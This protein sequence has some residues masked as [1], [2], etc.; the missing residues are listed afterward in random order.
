MSRCVQGRLFAW[1]V[2][3]GVAVLGGCALD[4][5]RPAPPETPG[6][7]Q[8]A[9]TARPLEAYGAEPFY[10]E[11]RF[12]GTLTI[13]PLPEEG[14]SLLTYTGADQPFDDSWAAKKVEFVA[15]RCHRNP[16]VYPSNGV[17][18]GN[19]F[20]GLTSCRYS[21]VT[22][23]MD[24]RNLK[25]DFVYNGGDVERPR[26]V[27]N[28]YGYFFVD[29]RAAF[30]R[31]F[32]AEEPATRFVL[33]DGKTYVCK[34][35]WDTM[36][37]KNIAVQAEGKAAIK[38]SLEDA[39]LVGERMEDA[40]TITPDRASYPVTFGSNRFFSFADN[41]R[42]D[43]RFE[44]IDLLP[45]HY[46]PPDAGLNAGGCGPFFAHQ[47][48]ADYGTNLQG[49]WI[50]GKRELVNC[51]NQA[52]A[53]KYARVPFPG[54]PWFFGGPLCISNNGGKLTEDS[55]DIAFYQEFNFVD[56]EWFGCEPMG[57]RSVNRAGNIF[58]HLNGTRK[59]LHA[60]NAMTNTDRFPT[61]VRFK[62]DVV[63]GQ[64]RGL[65]A[66]ELMDGRVT[67]YQLAS[68]TYWS[69]WGHL[70]HGDGDARRRG[71]IGF[72]D[73]LRDCEW[74][75][76]FPAPGHFVRD[77]AP[78]TIMT[79]RTFSQLCLPFVDATTLRT[80]E[81]IPVSASR[82]ARDWS[83]AQTVIRVDGELNRKLS[84]TQFVFE[85]YAFQALTSQ[86]FLVGNGEKRGE[87]G[88][89]AFSETYPDCDELEYE[90]PADGNALKTV[91]IVKRSRH[92]RSP[93]NA[94]FVAV[95]YWVYELDRPVAQAAPVFRV[96]KS[97]LE[98]ALNPAGVDADIRIYRAGTSPQG[99][100]WQYLCYSSKS[101]NWEMRNS[102]IRGYMRVSDHDQAVRTAADPLWTMSIVK[103]WKACTVDGSSAELWGQNTLKARRDKTGDDRFTAIVD[104]TDIGAGPGNMP[105]PTGEMRI[106]ND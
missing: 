41:T 5:S 71:W 65:R 49:R 54:E 69:Q 37:G 100:G 102:D 40:N 105:S 12:Y 50:C 55:S 60:G 46:T 24:G 67:A 57:L 52:E 93:T 94:P 30:A 22:E 38:F 26:A 7:G 27:T 14:K 45:P 34:G 78:A 59:K 75:L 2:A 81:M 72:R 43:V 56:V 103:S 21:R 6:A 53:R 61:R 90:D 80:F 99:I 35:G 62:A 8:P 16:P 104:N 17:T 58:R 29:C 20:P 39:F 73:P 63:A 18:N 68:P 23:V 95:P 9:A 87:A 28:A 101:L 25:V 82:Q 70:A 36:V 79:A 47:S 64:D 98:F 66:I 44:N 4:S 32:A 96:K 13:T 86:P 85:A 11:D 84:D 48:A 10:S 1:A 15:F 83:L 33:Q 31:A 74:R 88:P 91:R 3:A 92:S 89:Q 97:V 106:L 76:S 51:D 42:F 77:H 19:Y